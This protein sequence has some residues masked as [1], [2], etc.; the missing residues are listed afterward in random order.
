MH[1]V[2]RD[3][4]ADPL[5]ILLGID[6]RARTDRRHANRDGHAEESARNCSSCSQT[7]SSDGAAA[8]NRRNT[9]QR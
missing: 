6:T 7:S 8:T 1:S 9:P 5:Q 2:R 4:L 3:I